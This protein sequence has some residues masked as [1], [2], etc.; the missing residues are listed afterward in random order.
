MTVPRNR[1]PY[2]A[3]GSH[4]AR[5]CLQSPVS[6]TALCPYCISDGMGA[7]IVLEDP[8]P[9]HGIFAPEDV[10]TQGAGRMRRHS[11]SHILLVLVITRKPFGDYRDQ[12]EVSRE[13][14]VDYRKW[15]NSRGYSL[16]EVV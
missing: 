2:P 5:Y 7:D 13:L 1:F 4:Q 10:A 16:L 6:A 14:Y 15:S 11:H 9:H 12:V 8:P 3:F